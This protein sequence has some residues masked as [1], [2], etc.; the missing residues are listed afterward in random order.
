M[1]RGSTEWIGL[2]RETKREEGGWQTAWQ[3]QEG[4]LRCS[5]GD[6]RWGG[7]IEP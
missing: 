2:K 6:H 7:Q 1:R 4:D 3:T 5:V